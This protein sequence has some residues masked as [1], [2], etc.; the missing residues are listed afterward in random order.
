MGN[1]ATGG[2]GMKRKVLAAGSSVQNQEMMTMSY[3]PA[4]GVALHIVRHLVHGLGKT[5]GQGA[6]IQN[7]RHW[8]TMSLGQRRENLELGLE[9]AGECRWVEPGPN[10]LV[11]L[12]SLGSEKGGASR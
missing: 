2:S 9:Y 1:E 7:L 10:N 11:L 12:T 3:D 8:W 6:S 5:Q 4:E